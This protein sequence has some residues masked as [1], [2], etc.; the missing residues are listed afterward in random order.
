MKYL[1]VYL[2]LP[3]IMLLSMLCL[4]CSSGVRYGISQNYQLNEQESEHPIDPY[5]VNE[6]ESFW[7]ALPYETPLNKFIKG[8]TYRLFIG[9]SMSEPPATLHQG[10]QSAPGIQLT[11]ER[12]TE[13]GMDLLGTIEQQP[14]YASFYQS[15]KDQ[16]TYLLLL[17]ADSST[18][19]QK[20]EAQ[21]LDLK[22]ERK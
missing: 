2:R 18:V 21:W 9:V 16:L 1:S 12:P 13:N 4:A 14:F 10:L 15:S 11:H 7:K 17:Y 22:T 6:Y 20:Y 3:G 19:A 8:E 5:I